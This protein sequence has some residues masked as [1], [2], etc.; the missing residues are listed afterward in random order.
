MT[1]LA[2]LSTMLVAPMPAMAAPD[3]PSV[4][5]A[6][7]TEPAQVHDDSLETVPVQGVDDEA[8]ESLEDAQAN[9]DELAVLTDEQITDEFMAAGLT[10][11][12]EESDPVTEAS[13]RVREDGGW[14]DWHDLEVHAD[15]MAGETGRTG[16]EPL[17]TNGADGVQV[18]V[19]TVS[20]KEPQ[21]LE[22]SLID[23]GTAATD[24]AQ[25]P[26]TSTPKTQGTDSASTTSQSLR[27]NV[28]TRAQW[29]ANESWAKPATKMDKLD[30]MYL[31]HTAGT[32]TYTPAQSYQQLRSIYSY[33]TQSLRWP[34]IGYHFLVDKYGTIFQG[35]AGS[36]DSLVM[37][38]QAGGFNTN[39]IGVSAMGNYDV[40]SPPAEMV[41]S[42]ESVFAWQASTH[43]LNPTGT[44][45]LT[46]RSGPRTSTSKYEVGTQ[47]RVNTIL[48]HRDT[49]ATACPGRYLYPMLSSIR[50]NVSHKITSA[51]SVPQ[52]QT[53]RALSY[54]MQPGGLKAMASWSSVPADRY[55]IMF[56]AAPHGGDNLN[57][58]P[59]IAGKTTTSTSI[60]LSVDPGES[61]QFAVRAI[62]GDVPGEQVY[63]GQHTGPISLNNAS[64]ILSNG[65]RQ[66]SDSKGVWGLAA[67]ATDPGAR[68][69]INRASAARQVFV[70]G[71]SSGTG[72]IEVL[73]GGTPVGGLRLPSGGGTCAVSLPG[74]SDV[75]LRTVGSGTTVIERVAL[76]RSGQSSTLSTAGCD[77]QFADNPRGSG[78]FADVN[79]M[80]WSGLSGGYAASNTYGK[81]HQITR[82]ESLAFIQRYI[83]PS[84]TPS[85]TSVFK[86]VPTTH[87]F[88]QAISW[89]ASTGVAGGYTDGRFRPSQNVTRGEFA[90]LLYRASGQQHTS[91]TLRG[92]R[93]VPREAPHAQAIAWMAD[94]G[95]SSGYAD[96]TFRPS[97]P[98]TRAEVAALM[99]RFD[100][101]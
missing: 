75:T 60:D 25:A 44:T 20:G 68:L 42:I 90:S 45:T 40:V 52:T 80:Q 11:L 97:R 86:D 81:K 98:I 46:A 51:P 65:M 22:L 17:L 59:W 61:A 26:V 24:G 47:V 15:Q 74:G 9:D 38:S 93:D 2:A 53:P 39:T 29:G 55:Q 69:Q 23:P 77:R 18:K 14:T 63:L 34:D 101:R 6:P 71:R 89:G 99:H 19:L 8:L 31:H 72:G 95:I 62:R 35:R 67:R 91:S 96:G 79:W 48:G 87:T 58:L 49:N 32:N 5:M 100:A 84:H 92:F 12:A 88:H 10:W 54:Q 37:G 83:A 27:P 94:T 21:G 16:T 13:I 56:R 1:V 57:T 4:Q 70:T 3:V 78:Y 43:G 64:V 7:T 33:H 66:I 50:Q 85:R 30:A 82:G 28:V 36:M 73:Q 41:R 76:V